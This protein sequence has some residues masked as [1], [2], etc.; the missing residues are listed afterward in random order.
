MCAHTNTADEN[1]ARRHLCKILQKCSWI[2]TSTEWSHSKL[3]ILLCQ[4]ERTFT[5][6]APFP[7]MDVPSTGSKTRHGTAPWRS[8]QH[9]HLTLHHG[10]LY[11]SWT[12]SP[13][14]SSHSSTCPWNRCP[15]CLV[16]SNGFWTRFLERE[17]KW[18]ESRGQ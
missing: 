17:G 5:I 6:S 9:P 4:H 8:P 14:L 16:P 10:S 18:R 15:P 3:K 7:L 2:Y 12:P 11:P 1:S 13:A